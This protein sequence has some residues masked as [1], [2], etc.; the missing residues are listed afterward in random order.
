MSD[1]VLG[2][3]GLD[4]FG[5]SL[6]FGFVLLNVALFYFLLVQDRACH[7]WGEFQWL[8]LG[9]AV[10]CWGFSGVGIL[11]SSVLLFPILAWV[12][13]LIMTIFWVVNKRMGK[14]FSAIGVLLG[15]SCLLFLFVFSR[16]DLELLLNIVMA[17]ASILPAI[18]L[19]VF[20]SRFH[21][22]KQAEL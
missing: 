3:I 9:I 2:F 7:E 11:M 1:F 12:W 18:I 16:N 8:R 20:L 4:A 14:I 13:L 19:A 15:L 10:A 17:L 21:Y 22:L 5:F 6:I